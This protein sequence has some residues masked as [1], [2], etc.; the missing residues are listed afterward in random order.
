VEHAARLTGV[1]LVFSTRLT[2]DAAGRGQAT[3]R[4]GPFSDTP[5]TKV[6]AQSFGDAMALSQSYLVCTTGVELFGDPLIVDSG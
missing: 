2:Q 4:T 6:V 1:E 5:S 3:T